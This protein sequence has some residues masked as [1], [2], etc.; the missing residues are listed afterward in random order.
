MALPS[1]RV[2]PAEMSFIETQAANAGLPVSTYIRNLASNKIVTPR[3]TTVDDKLLFEL[4]RCGVNLHQVVK[5]LNF[6]QGIPSDISTVMDELKA[7]LT[8][9]GSRYDT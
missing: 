3:P 5:S 6:G 2:S 9:V 8:K 1:I 7:V 4:N